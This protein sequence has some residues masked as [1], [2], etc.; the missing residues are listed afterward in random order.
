MAGAR[1]ARAAGLESARPHQTCIAWRPGGPG[2]PARPAASAA[3]STAAAKRRGEFQMP[4]Q[5]SPY[6]P[7]RLIAASERPPTMSGIPGAGGAM[8][9][10]SR[11]KNRPWKV[12]A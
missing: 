10:S 2:R 6:R 1:Q 9:A 8:S 12:T 4:S 11:S 3:I 7:A 5:P